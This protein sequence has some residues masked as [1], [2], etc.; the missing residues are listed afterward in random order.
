MS[1]HQQKRGESPNKQTNLFD[2]EIIIREEVVELRAENAQLRKTIAKLK[3][4][5]EE[6]TNSY[7]KLQGDYDQQSTDYATLQEQ[8]HF[9]ECQM[10]TMRHTSS[11]QDSKIAYLNNLLKDSGDT[12]LEIRFTLS[13]I[14][15]SAK[16]L[17][18]HKEIEGVRNLLNSMLRFI[19]TLTDYEKVDSLDAEIKKRNR[20]GNTYHADGDMVMKKE[21]NIEH[22]TGLVIE[23]QG[24]MQTALEVLEK[25]E[26]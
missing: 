15:C 16:Q 23:N 13:Q 17:V 12:G 18:D 7:T 1:K 21:T 5:A 3:E 14:I 11:F 4:E 19:G 26:A 8:Y 2:D 9:K 20:Q 22:N 6:R 10:E 25:E 24:S